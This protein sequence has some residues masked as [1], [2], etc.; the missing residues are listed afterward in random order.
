MPTEALALVSAFC[1]AA[2]FVAAKRGLTDTS[3]VAT[4]LITLAC[5][6]IVI[7]ATTMILDP[8][9]GASGEGVLIFAVTGV[10]A[11]GIGY[12]AALAG[13]NSLGPSI[14]VPIQQGGRV[15]VS[16]SGAVLLLHES[17]ELAEAVGIGAIVTG[18]IGISRRRASAGAGAKGAPI[19]LVR[20]NR[21]WGPGEGL[22][23]PMIAGLSFAAFD[24]LVRCFRC[25]RQTRPEY[26]GQPNI[27]LD[28]CYR[29][30][31]RGMAAVGYLRR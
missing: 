9:R 1:F 18:V 31:L 30:R 15:I 6:W 17:M 22:A 23:F 13:V 19:L 16:M 29:N 28:G 2:A 11:P 3:L 21:G 7:L 24:V 10:I 25:P 5:A 26:D 27:R 14:S 12:W 20:T 8:P 4:V